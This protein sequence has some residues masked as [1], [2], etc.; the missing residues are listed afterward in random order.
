MPAPGERKQEGTQL[1]EQ[2]PRSLCGG[3][4][5]QLQKEDHPL[6]V[7]FFLALLWMGVGGRTAK[8]P[9]G[10]L[11]APGER[12]PEPAPRTAPAGRSLRGDS[13]HPGGHGR[14]V[15]SRNLY[16]SSTASGPP[17]P[18][19]EGMRARAFPFRDP[20]LMLR[21]TRVG[22]ARKPSFAETKKLERRKL[23]SMRYLKVRDARIQPT[24]ILAK[25][26]KKSIA[27]TKSFSVQR[28]FASLRMTSGGREG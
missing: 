14:S 25:L 1:M 7:V 20:S 22:R 15:G 2:V 23:G 17:S 13:H 19:G 26:R 21:M 9:V 24:I 28:S 11:P 4:H 12:K 27:M 18:P 5:H 8:A 3:S 16:T 10:L 6:W